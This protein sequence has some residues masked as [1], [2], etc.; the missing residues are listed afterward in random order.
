MIRK[1]IIF[2]A[3]LITMVGSL[4]AALVSVDQRNYYLRGYVD[5][6]STTA[7]P[8]RIPRFGVNADLTQY[9]T[10]SDLRI[11]LDAMQ[12]IGVYWVR[13]IVSW[14]E[15]ETAPGQYDWGQWDTIF[16]TLEAYYPEMQLIP[17]F[18]DA[19]DWHAHPDADIAERFVIPPAD[20]ADYADFIAG[21]ASR[22]ADFVDYYQLWDEPNIRIAWGNRHPRP[23]EY[24]ALLQA[25]SEVIRRHDS[26]ARILAAAL[27]PTAETGPENLSDWI[28]LDQLYTLDAQQYV[29]AFA[30]KAYGFEH[31]PNDRDVSPGELNFSRVIGLREV[32]VSNADS[33]TPLWISNWGWNSLPDN[34]EGQP[35]IW[36]S[37]STTQQIEYTLAAMERAEVE[38]PWLGGMILQHWQPDEPVSSGQWGFALRNPEGMPTHLYDALRLHQSETRFGADVATNGHYP[39]ANPH[40]TYN[41]VWRFSSLGAD[42]GWVDD[43]RFTFEF[44]GDG[45]AL[46]VREGNY[47][48]Y[49]YPTIDSQPA[50]ALPHDSYGNAYLHLRSETLQP[51][52]NIISL[53][54]GL[55]SG[56]HK[57]Q[58]I[59]DELVPDELANRW[60]LVGFAVRAVDLAAPYERQVVIAW[61]IFAFSLAA[62][63]IYA[64]R[65]DWRMFAAP[66]YAFRNVL[67]NVG[68]IVLAV[69]ASLL[70]LI[71]MFLT[72]GDGAPSLF[73]REPL[74]L[75]LAIFSGGLLYLSDGALLLVLVGVVL[76]FFTAYH[77]PEI[78]VAITLF[79]SPFFLFPVELYQFA[80]PLAELL[81]I[82][83]ASA[84]LLRSGINWAQQ[85]QVLPDGMRQISMI[86][87][88]RLSVIDLTVVAW[89]ILGTAAL[90][91]SD[92][93][94][95][96]LTEYRTLFIESA[97]LYVIIRTLSMSRRDIA[98]LVDSLVAAAVVVSV[99]GIIMWLRGEGIIEA[100]G[101]ARRLASVYGSPNNVGLLLGR[102]MPIALAFLILPLDRLRRLLSVLAFTIMAV[103]A[104]LTQ[105]A[106]ALFVGLPVAL[107]SVMIL[108][109]RKRAILPLVLIGI[110]GLVGVL[111]VLQMPRFERLT[112]FS[113][114]TNFYRLRVW[115]SAINVIE[116]HPLTGLGL[117]Q[118]LYDFRGEY[119]LPDAWE[120]P[121]L[122]HP[123]NILLDFW[124]RLGLPG[125]VLLI[126]LIWLVGRRAF[127]AYQILW[128]SSQGFLLACVIGTLGLL[129]NILAHGLIDNSV[130][131]FDQAYIFMVVL[132]LVQAYPNNSAIDVKPQVVV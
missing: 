50:P 92:L 35:S 115:E 39:A 67:G 60:P 61:L 1:Y 129:T 69:A 106:G 6:L 23:I 9:A 40:A 112:D 113:Q 103:A 22:Y 124:V 58:V 95:P 64:F 83:T 96:A 31:S 29:D 55:S 108:S 24:V 14:R 18:Q 41:G 94:G 38:W 109:W 86:R 45:L 128:T 10:P 56:S 101:G 28:Y 114:G 26:N 17:V 72:W 97:V 82:I 46:I 130:F 117:D 13:Q 4:V 84:W 16:E 36:G 80:F 53:A 65:L 51:Q 19:P 73:R 52:V 34:W 12:A 123:H 8:H 88:P 125:V 30:G 81:L 127:R 32:M 78:A 116:D 20:P 42:A 121:E 122:S 79:W 59:V 99:I 57:L 25:A 71:G 43:S 119:I 49:L 75:G 37:V 120:E 70:L 2:T 118:F 63:A 102:A 111:L 100:E 3:V 66:L 7:L 62:A 44:A 107:T 87:I 91:W 47:V 74:Q 132:A 105:S 126:S 98:R 85:W 110:I 27:A 131:V 76:F 48:A 89:I 77:R 5:P 21:F 15:V 33:T 11:Q 54:E 104:L 68:Q 90:F 93:P